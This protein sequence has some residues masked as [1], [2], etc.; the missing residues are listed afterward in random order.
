MKNIKVLGSG[1]AKCKKTV[2]LIKKVA[3]DKAIEINLEKVED[4]SQIMAYK[5]MSTPAVVV[6]GNIVHKGGI[7]N[8]QQIE[9]WLV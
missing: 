9:Q 5:V 3:S 4:P 8:R 7:P 6:D 2:A 1:C